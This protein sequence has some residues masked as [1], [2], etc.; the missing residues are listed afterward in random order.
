[1]M[2]KKFTDEEIIKALECCI[3][4]E[5]IKACLK[6]ECPF[7]KEWGLCP[8]NELQKLYLDLINR[9]KAEIERLKTENK[10]YIEANQVIGHQRDQ[11]DKE[12]DE[13]QKQIDGLDVRENKIKVEAYKEFAEKIKE[14][15]K[16]AYDNN[17]EV[18]N[19]HFEKH[20]GCFNDTFVG[21]VEGKNNALI[22][23]SDFIDNL[24]KEMAGEK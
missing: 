15:I 6:S 19:E 23:L 11:R 17:I 4:S 2:T 9:Q 10:I 3:K 22:G 12:I 20:R 16:E 1:M 13:L 18:L 7:S 5:K 21:I 24:L 8:G 14:E